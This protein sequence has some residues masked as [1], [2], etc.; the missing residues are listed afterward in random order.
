MTVITFDASLIHLMMFERIT[1]CFHL[2]PPEQ[3]PFKRLLQLSVQNGSACEGW[4]GR[5]VI[6]KSERLGTGCLKMQY[7]LKGNDLYHADFRP[8]FL[9]YI[10]N[11][12]VYSRTIAFNILN[13]A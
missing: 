2:Q 7:F 5:E 10:E 9:S 13:R 11:C 6:F 3:S 12:S 8:L 4:N 1:C